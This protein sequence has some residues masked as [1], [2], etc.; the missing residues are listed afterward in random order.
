MQ[1][2]P[3]RGEAHVALAFEVGRSATPAIFPIELGELAALL[4]SLEHG[5]ELGRECCGSGNRDRTRGQGRASC[6]CRLVQCEGCA[7]EAWAVTCFP[8]GDPRYTYGDILI[9]PEHGDGVGG[10]TPAA[11][12][13]ATCG[14]VMLDQANG[15]SAGRLQVL[16]RGEHQNT[17]PL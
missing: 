5:V 4:H 10:L 12:L 9:N 15:R 2:S 11:D 1:T 7:F 13:E 14:V 17:R 8:A 3:C 16:G 6:F